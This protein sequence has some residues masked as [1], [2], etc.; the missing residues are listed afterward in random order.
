MKEKKTHSYNET[1][2]VKHQDWPFTVP[3]SVVDDFLDG[4]DVGHPIL[5]PHVVESHDEKPQVFEEG[6]EV[7]S[8]HGRQLPL[9]ESPAC[10]RRTVPANLLTACFRGGGE[11]GG[12]GFLTV[13]PSSK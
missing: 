8:R 9:R 7:V 10:S 13:S 5:L 2:V 4:S 3:I 1:K 6:I 11:K 12:G